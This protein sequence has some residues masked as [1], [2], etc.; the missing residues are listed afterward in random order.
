V[1]TVAALLQVLHR[2]LGRRFEVT[3]VD[4]VGERKVK[5]TRC[6]SV[7]QQVL[8]RCRPLSS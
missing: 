1:R 6:D 5:P 3:R 4:R 2:A 7:D 8:N